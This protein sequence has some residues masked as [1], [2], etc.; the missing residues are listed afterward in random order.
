MKKKRTKTLV[1]L[2]LLLAALLG[3]YAAL[4]M[5][6]KKLDEKPAETTAAPDTARILSMEGTVTEIS[7]SSEKGLLEFVLK[8]GLWVEKNN[9]GYVMKQTPFTTMAGVFA[10]LSATHVIEETTQNLEE[11]GLDKPQ[12]VARAKTA[13]GAETVLYVGMQNTVTTEY[14]VYT[15]S[16]PGVY[17]VGTTA[18]NYF[19]RG[20]MDFAEV[21]DFP[22][23]SNADF[24]SLE[25]R[26]G[27][28]YMKTEMLKESAYD[29]SGIITWYVT[30]P[31]DHEYVAHTS[32]LDKMFAGIV[33]LSYSGVA[34][35]RPDEAQRS[36]M[37]LDQPQKELAFTY[38]E[39]A[40]GTE[41]ETTSET[42]QKTVNSYRLHIGNQKEGSDYYYVQEE[43][44]E[45]VL[46][47]SKSSLDSIISYTSKDLVN[48][49]FA[50]I[51]I[52]SVDSIDI[53]LED[54]SEYT[55]TPPASDAD[56]AAAEEQK[57]LYQTI[58]SIHAE[59]I[60]DSQTGPFNMLPLKIR[61]NRNTEPSLFEIQ[62]AEYDTSYYL[63]IADGEGIY[64]VNKRDYEK[65]C[66]DVKAGFEGLNE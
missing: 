54:G 14:Y 33:E 24:L 13:E 1:L 10:N 63:A 51:N 17:T 36:G 34:A 28:E 65:Y 15:D 64:L 60:V 32:T 4:Q 18:I 49:Y 29:M 45:L 11:Y 58:I 47:M 2:C 39:A 3:A 38:T 8:D 12:Y 5:Y 59:K 55:L 52:D 27:E 46:L 26:N 37:G 22:T 16:V 40:E 6:N 31:F 42:V 30:E 41:T 48:K 53:V 44:S 20:L 62:F 56:D 66:E 35:Y 43:G 61:F 9:P 57:S 50:L 23:V 21:P 7:V 19:A 25:T